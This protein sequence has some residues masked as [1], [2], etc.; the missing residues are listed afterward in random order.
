MNANEALLPSPEEVR[1]FLASAKT[2]GKRERHKDDL[3]PYLDYLRRVELYEAKHRHGVAQVDINEQKLFGALLSSYFFR[4]PLRTAVE[5]YKFYHHAL[6]AVDFKKPTDFIRSA[7][8]E[9]GKLKPKKEK[10]ALRSP[11]CAR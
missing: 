9:I 5:K 8:A 7:E 10:D 11:G 2:P 6:A 4:Q 1:D 3:T